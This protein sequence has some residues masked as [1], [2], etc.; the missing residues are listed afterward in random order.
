MNF[1]IYKC[2]KIN[3]IIK[4]LSNNQALEVKAHRREVRP[5]KILIDWLIEVSGPDWLIKIQSCYCL[6]IGRD[7]HLTAY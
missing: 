1:D 7:S 5:S 6:F 4:E 2:M 3:L